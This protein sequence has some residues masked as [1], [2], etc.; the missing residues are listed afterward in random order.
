MDQNVPKG[1]VIGPVQEG[2]GSGLF[3]Q[4]QS[5]LTFSLRKKKIDGALGSVRGVHVREQVPS[6][7]P[8]P[9]VGGRLVCHIY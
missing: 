6:G 3:T 4:Y 5:S 7:A 9:I 2:Q 1:L 8:G